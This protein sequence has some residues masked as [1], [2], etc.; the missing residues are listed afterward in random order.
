MRRLSRGG[1]KFP[2]DT[3]NQQSEGGEKG[4]STKFVILL[5][6]SELGGNHQESYAI[7]E[8]H[9]ANLNQEQE[10]AERDD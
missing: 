2:T 9:R 6:D 1:S 10:R 7:L 8:V 4:L 3:S 5:I